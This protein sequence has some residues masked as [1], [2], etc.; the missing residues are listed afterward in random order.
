MVDSSTFVPQRKLITDPGYVPASPFIAT[1]ATRNYNR[2]NAYW[3]QPR[4]T[5]GPFQ[6]GLHGMGGLGQ[7]AACC[8]SCAKGGPCTGCLKIGRASCRERV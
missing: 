6:V 4:G 8:D 7:L 1:D 5:L 3:L 2:W